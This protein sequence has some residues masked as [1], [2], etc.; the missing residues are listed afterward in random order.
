M[1]KQPE[2]LD[3][4][5]SLPQ[6]RRK[7]GPIRYFDREGNEIDVHAWS[8]IFNH[9]DRQLATTD[10]GDTTVDTVW[11]GITRYFDAAGRPLVYETLVAGLDMDMH[12]WPTEAEALAGHHT[13]CE[14]LRIKL[15][16]RS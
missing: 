3:S 2:S 8:K 11:M 1:A 5:E 12:H 4:S 15:A 16:E 9:A 13:I 7:H 10:V 14:A 6:Q